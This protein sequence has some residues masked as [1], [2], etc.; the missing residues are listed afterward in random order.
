ML[1][2]MTAISLHFNKSRSMCYGL[3]VMSFV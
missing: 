2:E 3:T 1:Q